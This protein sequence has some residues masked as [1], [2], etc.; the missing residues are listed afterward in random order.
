VSDAT[1]GRTSL[2]QA[3]ADSVSLT[4][5]GSIALLDATALTRHGGRSA[6]ATASRPLPSL[7]KEPGHLC[8][9]S[10]GSRYCSW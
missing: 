4:N 5:P 10:T 8:T 3:L 7:L 9:I 2:R 1:A 6:R